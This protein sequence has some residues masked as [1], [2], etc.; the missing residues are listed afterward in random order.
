MPNPIH[1]ENAHLFA[2]VAA[3]RNNPD[4]M[5][6]DLYY[7]YYPKAL[8]V[9]DYTLM[10]ELVGN[11]GVSNSQKERIIQHLRYERAMAKVKKTYSE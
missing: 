10:I 11:S 3:S 8:S 5:A 1:E 6:K 4:K 7:L 9:G 2:K